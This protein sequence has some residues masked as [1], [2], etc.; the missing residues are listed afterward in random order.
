MKMKTHHRNLSK[1]EKTYTPGPGQYEAPSDF[2]YLESFKTSPRRN[3]IR[4]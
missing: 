2:G 1:L 4:S 3:G